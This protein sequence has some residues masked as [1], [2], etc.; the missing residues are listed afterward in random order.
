[1]LFIQIWKLDARVTLMSLELLELINCAVGLFAQARD[2][3]QQEEKEK[4]A[5]SNLRRENV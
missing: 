2:T 4:C 5:D 3:A 1:M